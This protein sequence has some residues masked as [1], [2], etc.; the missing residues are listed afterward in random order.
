MAK[1]KAYANPALCKGCGLCVP[2]CPKGAVIPQEIINQKGYPTVKV[3]LEN[4]IGCGNC[5][6]ICP[7]Y[8]FEIDGRDS[9]G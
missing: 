8:V 2:E 4:C 9:P 7:D 6:R 1:Q 3:D 5:Y